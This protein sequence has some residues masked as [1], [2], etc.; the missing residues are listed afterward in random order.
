LCSDAYSYGEWAG[1]VASVATG[2]IGGTKAVAAASSK[3]GVQYGVRLVD[4]SHSLT[5]S[6]KL[7]KMGS[8]FF[9]WLNK[10]GN[11]LNGDYVPRNLHWRMDPVYRTKFLDDVT[12]AKNPPFSD[13][14][15]LINRLPYTPAGF[16]Y[17]MGSLEF[18]EF[19][20]SGCE[21]QR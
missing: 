6:N 1:V 7:K 9:S 10:K 13:F 8:K 17:G 2:Y 21:C 15:G 3:L 5:P 20:D 14:R 4:F 12:R 19:L 11:R 16:L 18:N